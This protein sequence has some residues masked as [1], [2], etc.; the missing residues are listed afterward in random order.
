MV[1]MKQ[2]G[3]VKAGWEAMCEFWNGR[4]VARRPA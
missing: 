3:Y 4:M 2:W 1:R